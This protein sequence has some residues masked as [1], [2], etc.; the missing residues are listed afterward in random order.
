MDDK[1]R[2]LTKGVF[3]KGFSTFFVV[4]SSLFISVILNRT[5]G[6]ELYGYLILVFSITSFFVALVDI[7][8]RQTINRFIPRY[9]EKKE[10]R[11]VKSLLTSSFVILGI[12]LFIFSSLIFC[13]SKIIAINIFKKPDL[14]PLLKI[15]ALFFIAV[16]LSEF[17]SEIFQALQD[18]KKEIVVSMGYPILYLSLTC[19]AIFLLKW[20]IDSVIWANFIASILIASI[21]IKFIKKNFIAKITKEEFKHHARTI[22]SF[23]LPV[24]LMNLNFYLLMW[25]DKM[26]LGR[27]H[28]AATLTD[29]YIAFIFFNALMIF[30]KVLFVVFR[31]YFSGLSIYLDNKGLIKERFQLLFRWFM[32]S[33]VLAGIMSFFLIAPVIR[34]FYGTGYQS[35]I[36]AF[37]LLLIIFFM[38]SMV[39]PVGI[40]MINV[41]GNTKRSAILST[42]RIAVIIFFDILLIPHYGYKGA[43]LAISIGYLVWWSLIFVFFKQFIYIFC[44]SSLLKTVAVSC[45]LIFTYLAINHLVP[46]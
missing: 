19:I 36:I 1:L 14:Y 34:L 33:S 32:H 39:Q 27:F 42:I 30:F 38:R 21:A 9:L 7:G 16:S 17:F 8:T 2:I 40:F 10:S 37:R 41:F 29:Y 6:K 11:N 46:I 45:F 43:I 13:Y 28:S 23:G 12:A 24:V 20:K 5:Y 26:V 44:Y 15:G 31:P 3:F 35:S 4:L 18:W 22:F 25:F